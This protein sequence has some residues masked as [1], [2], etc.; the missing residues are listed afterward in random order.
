MAL[1]QKDNNQIPSKPAPKTPSPSLLGMP[2][3]D[4]DIPKK[5]DPQRNGA[6][7]ETGAKPSESR[8]IVGPNIK[9]K[10]VEIE[11]CDTLVVEGYVEASMDSRVIEVSETGV[12]KGTVEIDTAIIRGR[13]EGELTA[14]ERLIVHTT[15]DV[16][17][18]IRYGRLAIDEGGRVHGD[19][20]ELADTPAKP[21]AAE[22]KKDEPSSGPER[23]GGEAA[24]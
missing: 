3:S 13:F 24:E 6:E 18:K 4:H 9:L 1:F 12:Y 14:R 21:N 2:S 16:S 17:G 7:K 5:S 11:D 20:D 8:L 10:G 15:G 23:L 22:T 19:L